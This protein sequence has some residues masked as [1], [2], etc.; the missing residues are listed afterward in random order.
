YLAVARLTQEDDDIWANMSLYHDCD[1]TGEWRPVPFDM[2]VSW[3]LSFMGGG[4]IATSDNLRSHPFFG[5]AN[6]GANQGYNRLYDA[7]VRQLVDKFIEPRRRHFYVTHS[8]TN[9][10]RPIGITSRH[11]AGIPEEQPVDAKVEFGEIGLSPADTAQE[12]LCLT[13]SNPFAVDIS[14]W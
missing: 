12:Y 4:V 1:G 3:G 11:N 2:N 8:V 6:V 9:T 10:A 5:A 13:N 14:G 7:G